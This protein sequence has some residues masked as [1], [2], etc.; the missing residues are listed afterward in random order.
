MRSWKLPRP[1]LM[2]TDPIGGVWNYTL[3]LCRELRY[4]EIALA[5]MGRPLHPGERQEIARLPNV[6]LFESAFALEWMRDPWPEVAAAGDWLYSLAERIE[7]SLVHLNQYA[8]GAIPWRMPCL[9]VGHSC[10]YSWF[11]AVRAQPPGEEWCR[12]R[13]MVMRGLG[14]ADRVTAPSCWM[15]SELERIYGGFNTA[16]AIPNGRHPLG[17]APAPKEKF[18]F[19]AGRL[20]D[21]AKN[22]AVLDQIAASLRWPIYAAGDESAPDGDRATLHNLHRLGR[23]DSAAVGRWMAHAAIFALPARY[24]PFGLSILEAALAGCALVVGDIPSL[25]EIWRDCALFVPPDD[26]DAIARA[27]QS[28]TADPGRRR[29]LARSARRRAQEFTPARTAQAYLTMYQ[30]MLADSPIH[31]GIPAREERQPQA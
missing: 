30:K 1:I 25:R 12:Y 13:S 2:T 10:V 5:S 23:L 19:T 16:A 15:L 21:P 7:P 4:C 17:F 6:E 18:I 11:D 28:L 14:G 22:I 31:R 29:E 3:D 8:H 24:E 20:W 9:I 26:S 27:L